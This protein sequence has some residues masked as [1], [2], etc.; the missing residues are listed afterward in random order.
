VPEFKNKNLRLAIAQ[1]I[2]K[3]GYVKTVLNDGSLA[4]NNFTGFIHFNIKSSS[5]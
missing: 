4:S 3:K 1:A 2:N 5:S